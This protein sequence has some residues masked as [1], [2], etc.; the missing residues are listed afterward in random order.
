MSGSDVRSEEKFVPAEPSERERLWLDYEGLEDWY[1][2][3][4]AGNVFCKRE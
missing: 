4:P 3:E 2:F 1:G